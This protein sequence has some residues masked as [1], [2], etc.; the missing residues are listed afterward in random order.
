VLKSDFFAENTRAVAYQKRM[1]SKRSRGAIETRQINRKKGAIIRE[2]MERKKL[3]LKNGTS[4]FAL[5]SQNLK[6]CITHETHFPAIKPQTT[7]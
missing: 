6:T 1:K 5:F 2:S 4:I 7:Q 3:F